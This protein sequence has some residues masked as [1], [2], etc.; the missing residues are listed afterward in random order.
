MNRTAGVRQKPVN[1]VKLDI[2]TFWWEIS[3]CNEKNISNF[4]YNTTKWGNQSKI[5]CSKI[6]SCLFIFTYRPW[7]QWYKIFLPSLKICLFDF[8]SPQSFQIAIQTFVPNSYIHA[9]ISVMWP[10]VTVSCDLIL[11]I[12][13]RWGGWSLYQLPWGKRQGTHWT[14]HQFFAGLT[15]K[16]T[17]PFALTWAI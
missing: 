6:N 13:P 4:I 11:S 7:K 16:N 5:K 12:H 17:Q 2:L 10:N 9:G 14:G 15:H 3:N 8:L 1:L